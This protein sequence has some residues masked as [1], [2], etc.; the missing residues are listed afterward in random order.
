MVVNLPNAPSARWFSAFLMLPPF[1]T[2]PRVLGE[3]LLILSTFK[4]LRSRDPDLHPCDLS[5]SMALSLGLLYFIQEPHSVPPSSGPGG[6]G[7]RPYLSILGA[8]GLR[9]GQSAGR[10]GS[11]QLSPSDEQ[12]PDGWIT[13]PSR[14]GLLGTQQAR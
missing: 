4:L 11:K 6:L 7:K 14:A 5:Q 3:A 1:N 12:V 8:V 13:G 9:L 10:R 2:G